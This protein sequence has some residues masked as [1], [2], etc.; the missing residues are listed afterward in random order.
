MTN[1][2]AAAAGGTNN[3]GI[4]GSAD[5]GGGG[6]GYNSLN[7]DL[8]KLEQVTEAMANEAGSEVEE[9]VE[10]A[11]CEDYGL[12]IPDTFETCGSEECPH[13]VKGEWSVC[14]QSRCF[15]RNTAIQRREV[16]CRFA[17]DT[18]SRLCP[19]YEK[20]I[21]R[22]ECYNERCRGVW[23]VEPWSEVNKTILLCFLL[24]FLV[25]F[26]LSILLY[27]LHMYLCRL[28]VLCVPA[29]LCF[30]SVQ[31]NA[32][33]GRQGIKYRILQ[34]VWYGTRRPAGNACKHQNR[35]A[36][37]KVCK[38]PP[39]YAKGKYTSIPKKNKIQMRRI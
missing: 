39:C 22:Q 13:W 9:V 14:H 19:E 17:N 31:C 33:C 20:P 30:P 23:R 3:D 34:C 11:F 8:Q 21:S 32:P 18:I 7:M 24:C 4:G 35:P 26:G 2:R 15:G 27:H 1:A 10:N 29:V 25:L 6:G 28:F 5:D 36:V 12:D 16:S 37:M 38:S